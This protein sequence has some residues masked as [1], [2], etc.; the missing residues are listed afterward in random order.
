VAD[1]P[2][3]PCAVGY[4]DR[5]T[6][7]GR[8]VESA[9]MTMRTLP[10]PMDWQ[11]YTDEGHDQAV[12]VGRVDSVTIDPMT[13]KVMAS[14]VWLDP[15]IIPAVERAKYL[16]DQK[17]VYPSMEPAGCSMEWQM[18]GGGEPYYDAE[19]IQEPEPYGE[20]CVFTAFEF[21]KVTLVSVQAF[22]D[23][24]I[25]APGEA[26]PAPQSL[27]ASVRSDGWADMPVAEADVEWDGTAAADRVAEWAGTNEE[28][29]GQDA[30]DKYASAFLYQDSDADPMS[31][32]AYK[33]GVADVLDGDLH[34]IP[35][36]VYAVAGVL[37]GARGGADIPEAQ[38]EE[39]KSVVTGLY[40]HLAGALDDDTIEAPFALTACAAVSRPPL[41]YFE[42][43]QLTGPTPITVT[44]PDENGWRRIYGHMG[45]HGVPHR[46]L[47]GQVGI[48]RSMS[49][50]REFL[51]GLTMTAEG[52]GIPT[53]KITIGGGHA[54]DEFGQQAA[55]DHYDDVSTTIA[56]VT[57]GD[58]T[59]GVWISG[60]I[61]ADATL[62]QI[63]ELLQSP[64]SGDWRTDVLGNLEMIGIHSVNNPGFPVYRVGVD[65]K[66]GYSLVA[67]S[68]LVGRKKPD[69]VGATFER[70]GPEYVTE[71]AAQL[72]ERLTAMSSPAR[73]AFAH[74]SPPEGIDVDAEDL[75]AEF[76]AHGLDWP[77]LVVEAD[78]REISS[79]EI[80]ESCVR[81]A[82]KAEAQAAVANELALRSARAKLAG[83]RLKML[84]EN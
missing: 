11:E 69:T 60:A 81:S 38:Q 20:V 75:R 8:V 43:P 70:P 76:S 10:L 77:M 34:I 83:L 30:W 16:A 2:W 47:P 48:P 79:F 33:L 68:A 6:S 46:G 29:A 23:L 41:A 40:K 28:D 80:A 5:P 54:A 56:N 35:A 62:A 21:A 39:L 59:F 19:G 12:T 31:K 22:P 3:G 65:N 15:A 57:A 14:G 73:T 45:Q 78:G 27:V 71:L 17:I 13:G 24:W 1:I 84:T 25:T 18:T 4:L 44:E 9:G 42:D 64:P 53:G 49:G 55:R 51:L 66:G 50:Y 7:D 72:H 37:N 26:S 82:L 67:S 63:D 36:A 74:I 52:T 61:R 58:D 32:G